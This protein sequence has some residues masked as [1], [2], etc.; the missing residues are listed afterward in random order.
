[1]KELDKQ[2]YKIR[3]VAEIIGVNTS[4]LRYWEEEFKEIKPRRSP[5]NQRYYKPEDI[6]TLRIVYY[7]IKI[8][9]LRIEAA[10]EELAHNRKNISKRIEAIELLKATKKQL[11]DLLSALN[12]RK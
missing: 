4:T 10:K 9:G 12:K 8:K 1:M 2:Y 11:Q 5:T 6:E 3:D 7:L